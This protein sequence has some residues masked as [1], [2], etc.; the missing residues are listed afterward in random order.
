MTSL[1]SSF[2]HFSRFGFVLFI[3]WLDG[4]SSG[5]YNIYIYIYII[6]IYIYILYGHWP[7]FGVF[8]ESLILLIEICSFGEPSDPHCFQLD[9]LFKSLNF[10]V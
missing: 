10:G 7:F 2:D 9:F 1:Y 4:G 6:Y 3:F 5:P 8:L